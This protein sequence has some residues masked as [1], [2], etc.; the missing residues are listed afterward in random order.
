VEYHILPNIYFFNN[1][2]RLWG[3]QFATRE[4]LDA[5]KDHLPNLDNLARFYQAQYNHA[6]HSWLNSP[7]SDCRQVAN[8]LQAAQLAQDGKFEDCL[9]ICW[10]LRLEL[11]PSLW[12][13]A[14]VNL[15]IATI[16]DVREHLDAEKFANECINLVD[17]MRREGRERGIRDEDD[18][19]QLVKEATK[20][21]EGI[22]THL[23]T[24]EAENRARIEANGSD[25]T[26]EEQG[27]EEVPPHPEISIWLDEVA[28]IPRELGDGRDQVVPREIEGMY[29]DYTVGTNGDEGS[30]E[31]A[32]S[33]HVA[34]PVAQVSLSTAQ[35]AEPLK[36]GDG[37]RRQD[38]AD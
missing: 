17:Q 26:L 14:Y 20:A 7:S 19:D 3:D 8:K 22:K 1:S 12:R 6:T 13:R 23:A 28:G 32:A 9:D 38:A 10:E 5:W 31:G 29:T 24:I 2:R 30:E 34:V 35:H 27:W 37:G 33:A 25:L 4:S 36:S 15:L 21:R 18:L 11:D 16:V